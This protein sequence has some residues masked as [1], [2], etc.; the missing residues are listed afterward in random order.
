MS[1]GDIRRGAYAFHRDVPLCSASGSIFLFW[2]LSFRF[3]SAPYKEI[4]VMQNI[5]SLSFCLIWIYRIISMKSFM[6]HYYPSLEI[7]RND[8][9]ECKENLM[10]KGKN[11]TLCDIMEVPNPNHQT[12]RRGAFHEEL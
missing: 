3:F 11:A 1:V 10:G 5:F 2:R 4:H 6:V 8:K 12:Q 7:P 9:R